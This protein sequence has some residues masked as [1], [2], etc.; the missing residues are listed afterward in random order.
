[1]KTVLVTD[2]APGNATEVEVPLGASVASG[3]RTLRGV[4]FREMKGGV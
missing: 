4:S 2:V 1:M 3:L